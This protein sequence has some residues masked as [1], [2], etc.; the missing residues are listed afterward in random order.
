MEAK[1]ISQKQ[2]LTVALF[3]IVV[4]SFIST[5]LSMILRTGMDSSVVTF[6]RL[7]LVSLVMLPW[8]FSKKEY[9]ENMRSIS[10][11][12]WKLFGIYCLTK[13][14]G[15]VLW[16]EGLRLGAPAFTMSTLS[17][18]QPIFV[19]VFVYLIFKEKTSLRSLGG[20]FVCLLGVTIIGAD[21]VSSLGSP[22]ALIVIV[23]CCC[24]NALNNVFGRR[25]R[26]N[27][28]LIPMMGISYFVAGLLSG[29]YALSRGASF[30]VPRAAILHLLGVSLGC[31]LLGHSMNMWSLKYIKSVTMSILSLLS[32]FC[33]AVSAYFLLDEVPQPIVFVGAFFMIAG[34]LIYQR[35]EHQ[36]HLAEE[37][38][39]AGAA[40]K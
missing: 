12:L 18:M 9:R 6:Y 10:P 24:C 27:M 26:Q 34:L 7:M 11:G 21:N 40:A 30:A 15:F 8:A 33:T 1:S 14:G 36:A 37:A 13:V 22:I 19:V 2:A 28:D 31:T 32:P 23:I 35:A 16:A 20:I 3:A 25:V 17:N 39:A 38:R 29:L 4:N 5:F